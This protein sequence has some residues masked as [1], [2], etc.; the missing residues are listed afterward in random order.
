MKKLKFTVLYLMLLSFSYSNAAKYKYW[1]VIKDSSYVY[2][3]SKGTKY[4]Y[5]QKDYTYMVKTNSN[6]Q[7]S[8]V[9]EFTINITNGRVP[10][11][12]PTQIKVNEN[13][14]FSVQWND[15]V[16]TCIVKIDK[17]TAYVPTSDTLNAFNPIK[18]SYRVA[19][20][21]G[22]TPAISISSN[23]PIG[24]KE[25]ITAQ[26]ITEATYSNLYLPWTISAGWANIPAQY[27]EWT[28]PANW[29]AAGQSGTTFILSA[30]DKSITITPDYV[31]TGEIKVR[32]LNALKTAGSDIKSNTLDRGF[33]F[34]AFPTSI[35]FGDNT[36]KTFSTTLFNGITYE[37]NAPADWKINSQGYTL[38]SLNLNSV[39]VS[40]SFCQQSDNK[41]RVRLK[42]NNEIS[43]WYDFKDFLGVIEPTISTSTNPI[44]QFEDISFDIN[45]VNYSGIQS[46]VWSSSAALIGNLVSGKQNILP[47]QA[48]LINLDVSFNLNNCSTPRIFR[49]TINTL[50]SRLSLNG[51]TMFCNQATYT[52]DYL[53]S[54]SNLI[55]SANPQ[56]IVSI[57]ATSNSA[58]LSKNYSGVTNL[59]AQLFYQQN[60]VTEFN[61]Q[62][63]VS[64][65]SAIGLGSY[66]NLEMLDDVGVYFKIL[67]SGTEWTYRGNLTVSAGSNN[68]YTWSQVSSYPND[69]KWTANG[70]NIDVY[71]RFAN[72]TIILKCVATSE[73]NSSTKYYT[74][75]TSNLVM[76]AMSLSPNP[77]TNEVSISL[78]EEVESFE[79]TTETANLKNLKDKTYII[80]L[81]SATGLIKSVNTKDP[82]YKLS[83]NG[84]STG[85]YYIHVI[86]GDKIY[87]KQLI[88]K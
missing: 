46:V 15:V 6:I 10:G 82:S 70:A 60:L 18:F 75:T 77:A 84:V 80:Q 72:K 7:G 3:D 19:S 50:P 81:W 45:N 4:V 11:S 63:S 25:N 34:S 2:K 48:G 79:V 33:N 65:I 40:P 21:K 73:C 55:W 51:P 68:T 13:I 20:L 9:G 28:L 57:Q 14:E 66:N 26:I 44:Y 39:S 54:M 59:K 22:Q 35:T 32:A 37:W 41:V 78:N 38:E 76:E 85:F 47:T 12:T 56:N 30:A 49:K 1:L 88:V 87:R 5:P 53:S 52:V 58:N 43:N 83:L 74:F 64:P 27:Y 62:I 69:I 16:D 31:T 42:M 86:S 36:A 61:K 8:G 23:P 29:H 24:N 71:T 67:P 17:A